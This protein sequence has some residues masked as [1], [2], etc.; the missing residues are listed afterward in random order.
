MKGA[1]TI[2][3]RIN[4]DLQFHRLLAEIT[5]NSIFVLLI[6]TLRGLFIEY[7]EYSFLQVGLQDGFFNPH[8]A[9]TEA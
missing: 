1:E 8:F 6:D 4:L 9:L 7:Q 5:Q 3:E 2:G